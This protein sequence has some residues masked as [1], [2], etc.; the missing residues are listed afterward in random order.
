M[1]AV[2]GRPRA[3]QRGARRPWPPAAAA[4]HWKS[5]LHQRIDASIAHGEDQDVTSSLHER[6]FLPQVMPDPPSLARGQGQ[7]S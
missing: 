5:P 3:V 2:S 7:R 4:K 6:C 1:E